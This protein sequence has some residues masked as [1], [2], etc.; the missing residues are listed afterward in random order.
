MLNNRRVNNKRKWWDKVYLLLEEI[1]GKYER[2]R[3][4]NAYFPDGKTRKN[5]Y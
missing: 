1:E 4:V 5:L 2:N 3:N